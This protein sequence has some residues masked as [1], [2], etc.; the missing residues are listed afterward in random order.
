MK[1]AALNNMFRTARTV[2]SGPEERKE[3]LTL[4]HEIAVSNGY[5]IRTPE[6]RRYRSERARQLENPTTDKIPLY[7]PYISN[8]MSAAIRR[9][10]R[11]ADLDSSVSVV[12][13][14]AN[15]LK[16]QLVR[17]RLYDTICT[18]P[19]CVICPTGRPGDERTVATS[20]SVKRHDRCMS[21]SKST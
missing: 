21:A 3:P 5:E 12:E 7:F 19:N 14:P 4:V 9:C 8:E 18:P 13:I 11:R 2:C 20:M 15:N 1:K 17:N 10:L 16:R 6:T